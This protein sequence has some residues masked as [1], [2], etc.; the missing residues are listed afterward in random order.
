MDEPVGQDGAQT[1]LNTSRYASDDRSAAVGTTPL[2]Y[3][4]GS[5]G[6]PVLDRCAHAHLIRSTNAPQKGC[7]AREAKCQGGGRTS[8]KSR[9]TP[10]WARRTLPILPRALALETA[11]IGGDPSHPIEP[12]R[13]VLHEELEGSRHRPGELFFVHDE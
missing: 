9:T 10:I 11:G 3:S 8:R 4:T 1:K 12:E 5:P 2:S 7:G 6:E 13:A